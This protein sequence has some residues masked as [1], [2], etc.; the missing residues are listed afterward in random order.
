MA[1][2]TARC[3][4]CHESVVSKVSSSAWAPAPRPPPSTVIAGIP[5]LMAIL[6]SVEPSSSREVRPSALL[7]D[8]ADDNDGRILVRPASRPIADQLLVDR[9]AGRCRSSACFQRRPP[10]RPPCES[11]HRRP[12]SAAGSADLMSTS[13]Q[14]SNAMAFTDVPPPTR[15]TLNV[16]FGFG[17]DLEV[18]HSGNRASQCVNRVGNAERAVAVAARPLERHPVPMASDGDV[19]NPEAGPVHGDE[20]VNLTFQRLVEQGLHAAQVAE[21]F[22]PHRADKR[23]R[24]RRGHVGL[25]HRANHGEQHRQAAAV[26]AD[27]GSLEDVSL[28]RD[29]DVG[30]LGKDRVEM[31]GEARGAAGPP[32]RAARRARCPRG[33]DARS[34]IR[35][36]ET[37][38][39]MRWRAAASLNGGAGISQ[40]RIWSSIVRASSAR[41]ASTAARTAASCIR[42]APMSGPSCGAGVRNGGDQR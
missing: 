7:T 17:R 4:P 9:D 11:G 6:E 32:G 33:R 40:R 39:H 16:V 23:N 18:G 41:A 20:P 30:V 25:V 12:R 36:R 19:R 28:A 14:A 1:R 3:V 8:T 24:A 26:V 37:R 34:S 10:R 29:P 38:P 21:P 22:L 2:R 27:A 15:P 31:R 5:R 35:P 42:R 13:I